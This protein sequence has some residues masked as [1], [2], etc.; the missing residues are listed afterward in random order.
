MN[1]SQTLVPSLCVS[2]SNISH[3]PRVGGADS[4]EPSCSRPGQ[5][6]YAPILQL[7]AKCP[8]LFG[9]PIWRFLQTSVALDSSKPKHPRL[10]NPHTVRARPAENDSQPVDLNPRFWFLRA[11]PVFQPTTLPLHPKTT[12]ILARRISTRQSRKI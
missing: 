9:P 4:P 12:R 2:C 11:T 1:R 7:P 3:I 10:C 8:R 6:E 5:F